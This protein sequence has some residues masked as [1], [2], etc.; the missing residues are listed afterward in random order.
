MDWL[1]RVKEEKEELNKKIEKL[2]AFLHKKPDMESG[3]LLL[4]REQLYIMYCYDTVLGKRIKYEE[5]KNEN[6]CNG[7]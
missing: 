6:S 7:A 5:N 1:D 2:E 3:A 4:L